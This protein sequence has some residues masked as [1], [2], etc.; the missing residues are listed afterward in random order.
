MITMK[1]R[2]AS[3][4]I[5]VLWQSSFQNQAQIVRVPQ[6]TPCNVTGAVT[7]LIPMYT[8]DGHNLRFVITRP[9]GARQRR[10]SHY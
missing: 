6:Y 5:I 3:I 8:A 7:P 4:T 10:I 1:R 9:K 2:F